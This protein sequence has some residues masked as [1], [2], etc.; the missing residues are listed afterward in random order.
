MADT[1]TVEISALSPND[2]QEVRAI[3]Q[4]GIATGNATFETTAPD[5]DKWDSGHF[6]FCRLV[7]RLDGEVA[8]WAALSPVSARHV[9]R[10]V[11]E[12]SVYVAGYARGLGL[13]RKLLQT[14]IP[15]SERQGIWTIQAGIFPENTASLELHRAAGFRVI[16]KRERPGCL[17]GKWRDVMLLERRSLVVGV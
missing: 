8:G 11:A 5:W 14:L 13:G 15:E 12:I 1:R 10:G 17:D 9:Y 16:G 4:E 6:P 7:A 2:W 3:Y